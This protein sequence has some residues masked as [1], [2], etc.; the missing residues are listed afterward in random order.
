MDGSH[1]AGSRRPSAHRNEPAARRRAHRIARRESGLQQ[2]RELRPVIRH[3]PCLGEA[4]IQIGPGGEKVE[5]GDRV[6]LG[7]IERL[8]VDV[9][10]D[11]L[12]AVLDG[13]AVALNRTYQPD[14]SP[15]LEGDEVAVIPPVAGG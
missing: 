14:E 13:S 9:D 2:L 7:E 5:G 15:V 12:G 4:A 3:H 11:G 6:A 1:G 8:T 10:N